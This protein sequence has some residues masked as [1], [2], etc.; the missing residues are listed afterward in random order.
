MVFEDLDI[1]FVVKFFIL[2]V[3]F[4]IMM[5]YMAPSLKWKLMFP[6]AGALGIFMA[7]TGKSMKGMTPLGRKF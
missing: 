4:T 7:L 3:P 1:K 2:W 5:L 6:V